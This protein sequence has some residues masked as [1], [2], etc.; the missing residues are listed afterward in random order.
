MVVMLA[1]GRPHALR[2]GLS[3]IKWQQGATLVHDIGFIAIGIAV[4][5]H[6]YYALNSPEQLKSM[7]R[8]DLPALGAQAHACVGRRSRRRPAL[9]CLRSARSARSRSASDLTVP[10]SV[11]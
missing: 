6:L 5:G 10:G 11:S 3:W 2:A 9:R 8:E 1:T 4:L 7:L